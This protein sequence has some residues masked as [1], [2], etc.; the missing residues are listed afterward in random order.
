L[1]FCNCSNV[2]VTIS[3]QASTDEEDGGEK[4]LD[5]KR[6]EA[7]AFLEASNPQGN[8]AEVAA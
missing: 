4:F 5:F 3:S 2:T 8:Y 1:W 6:E 7:M